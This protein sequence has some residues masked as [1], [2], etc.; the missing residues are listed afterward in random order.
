MESAPR[1]ATVGTFDGVH[2]GHKLLLREL[3]TIAYEHGCR[4]SAFVLRSHPLALIDPSRVPPALS[5]FRQKAAMVADC[6]VEVIPLDFDASLQRLTSAQ[7]M[8][9]LAREWQVT[10]MLIGYD[11]RFGS[12]RNADFIDYFRQGKTL[13]INVVQASELP[14]VSSSAVRAH[15]L[16]G[17]VA[18][19]ADKL[20]RPYSLEGTVVH[21]VHLGSRIGFP[22]ANIHPLHES[23]LVPARGVYATVTTIGEKH[24]PSVTNIGVRPTITDADGSMSIETHIP[25]LHSDLYGLTI[26]LDFIDK[27]REEQRFDSLA[28]LKARLTVDV[29][30]ALDLVSHSPACVTTHKHS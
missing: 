9:W 3:R 28:D 13:G 8:E 4:P 19:A 16:E 7:F 6:G 14:G 21:G 26:K 11:N 30:V 18:R 24:F 12:D 10:G 1:Y 29:S 15:L 2:R 17:A 25:G 23:L 27:I 5:T 20:G 22:T